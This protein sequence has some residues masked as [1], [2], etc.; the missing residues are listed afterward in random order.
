M[1]TIDATRAALD[2]EWRTA[3]DVHARI[4]CWSLLTIKK[5]LKT[6]CAAGEAEHR[7]VACRNPATGKPEYR[8]PAEKP[9]DHAKP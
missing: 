2:T 6:L 3:D 7:H 5:N 4:R 8:L 1:S 9:Y